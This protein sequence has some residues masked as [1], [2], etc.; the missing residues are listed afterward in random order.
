MGA[1]RRKGQF[2]GRMI[3]L[4]YQATTP[5]APEVAEAMRPWIEEKFANPH[6]PSTAGREAAAAIEIARGQVE[7]AIGLQGGKV[8]FT[9]S[10]TEAI[11][12]AIKGTIEKAA[13]GRTKVLTVQTEHAAVLDSCAWLE[14]RGF[15][16]TY[17]PV[18]S[19]GLVD[20][21]QCK[22]ALDDTVALVVVMLVNNE[23]G[24]IQ[25]VGEIAQAAHRAGALMLCD[26][27]Q[28][29]GRVEIPQGP[30]LVAVSAHKIHGPKGIGALWMRRGAEPA[31]LMHGGGQEQRLRSGTL[32]PA[33]CV[34]FG[35]A[36]QLASARFEDDHDHVERLWNAALAAL[37]PRWTV[38]GS[39]EQR[40]HGNLNICREGIDAAR[41]IS[42][43]RDIAFSLGSACASGSGRP[44]HV[45]KAIGLGGSEARSSIRIGFG[46]Y[47]TE[48][49][50]VSAVS[51]INEAAEAQE[52]FAA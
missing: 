36:A 52:R 3:Y 50:L 49:E 18:A 44:S 51:R 35:A 41:I 22:A 4:D 33:L 25:P 16:V 31:P 26:A 9:G 13:P 37:G 39:L 48:A 29:L 10:A 19:D 27:V 20:V 21:E 28:A 5:L 34:G 1:D 15:D 2:E 38:N 7:Q 17:L 46:R 43:L 47:T 6:S 8:A 23:I 24:V 14:E 42:D 40:Y 11:N 12:W 45:L 30:D 32:S